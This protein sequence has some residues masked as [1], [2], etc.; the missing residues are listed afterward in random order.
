MILARLAAAGSITAQT[1][2]VSLAYDLAEAWEREGAARKSRRAHAAALAEDAASVEAHHALTRA[3][4]R[5]VLEGRSVGIGAGAAPYLKTRLNPIPQPPP[6]PAAPS[7]PPTQPPTP[8]APPGQWAWP[9][10]DVHRDLIRP[11]PQSPQPPPAPPSSLAPPA[12]PGPFAPPRYASWD[13]A[14]VWEDIQG[15]RP[16]ETDG[17]DADSNPTRRPDVPPRK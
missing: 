5:P 1:A 8:P 4:P 7:Q 9:Y 16:E 13:P 15:I 12:T 14:E 10:P 17:E 3:P 6:S 2:M 11:P